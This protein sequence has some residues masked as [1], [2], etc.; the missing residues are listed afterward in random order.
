MLWLCLVGCA[1][2]A[3]PEL[4]PPTQ[5]LAAD[6]AWLASDDRDG[7]LTGSAGAEASA[8]YIA[9]RYRG[10]GLAPLPKLGY[11]QAF[12]FPW[13]TSIRDHTALAIGDRVLRLQ[14]DF[15]PYAFSGLGEFSGRPAF[16][17]YGVVSEQYHYDDYANV[18]VKGRVVIALR[19]EPHDIVSGK[20]R[21]KGREFTAAATLEAKVAAA[22][23]HG[24]AALLQ[25]TPPHHHPK[26]PPLP[27]FASEGGRSFEAPIP[28]LS[29]TSAV[30]DKLLR[31]PISGLQAAIDVWGEPMSFAFDDAVINGTVDLEIGDLRGTNVAAILPGVG[32]HANEFVVVGAHYDHLGRGLLF[33]RKPDSDEI[34]NGADDNASGVAAMLSVAQRLKDQRLPRSILF[35][36]FSGEEEGLRGSQAFV[37]DPPVPLDRIVAIVNLD[38]VGRVQ[39]QALWVGG[40]TTRADFSRMLAGA[41][42]RSPLQLS[43]LGEEGMGQSDHA[44]FA[45]VRIPGLFLFS[46]MHPQYHR[47][48]D[49]VKL[50]NFEG[51]NA[52]ADLASDLVQRIAAAPREPFVDQ[53]KPRPMGTRTNR[54]KPPATAPATTR[55]SK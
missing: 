5:Q 31:V 44:S 35:V 55:S 27:K 46:G 50:I 48:D 21:F 13:R 26:E 16:V 3:L 12:S 29:I 54:A 38:M 2:R 19:Y 22:R 51:L 49:D 24:A 23:A 53:P 33:S 52:V 20:S 11:R 47:P 43:D 34:H 37:A 39:N 4:P 6:V 8:D 30:A 40:G 15:V 36:A 41:D 18:D 10:L 32:P 42:H 25:V 9:A 28:V 17:G 14:Q 45:A 7:R 1:G